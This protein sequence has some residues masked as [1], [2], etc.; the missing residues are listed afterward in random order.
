MIQIT[1]QWMDEIAPLLDCS[2]Q[3]PNAAKDKSTGSSTSSATTEK[4]RKKYDR[5]DFIACRF[6]VCNFLS[7]SGCTVFMIGSIS[8]LATESLRFPMRS[9]PTNRC[10]SATVSRYPFVRCHQRNGR[11]AQDARWNQCSVSF[12]EDSFRFLRTPTHRCY[13]LNTYSS[14]SLCWQRR[15]NQIR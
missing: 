7:V 4:T 5:S 15:T 11:S 1:N 13:V 3:Q 14:V 10:Y 12:S 2:Y 9:G 8:F 6:S